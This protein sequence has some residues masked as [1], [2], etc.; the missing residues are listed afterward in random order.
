MCV[1][2][3]C[4][5]V[6]VCVCVRARVCVCVCICTYVRVC[7]STGVVMS[8]HQH[9][10]PLVDLEQHGQCSF[11][12]LLM[13]RGKLREDDRNTCPHTTSVSLSTTTLPSP[14]N[15]PYYH[16]PSPSHPF[17]TTTPLPHHDTPSSSPHPFLT[18]SSPGYQCHLLL[19]PWL[20]CALVGEYLEDVVTHQV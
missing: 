4:V 2:S 3:L 17:L 16:T 5:C 9:F 13:A 1:V 7:V 18:P 19:P 15:C 11:Q 12:N 14:P 8:T 20:Q 10:S 6:C